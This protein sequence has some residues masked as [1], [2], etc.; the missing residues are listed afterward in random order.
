MRDISCEEAAERHGLTTHHQEMDNGEYRF[1]LRKSDGTVYIRTESG[2]GGWQQ[3]HYHENVRETYIVQ[4]G[5][6][7]FAERIQGERKISIYRAGQQFTTEPHIIHN[8]YMPANA[9]IH[10]VKHGDAAGEDRIHDT[11][12][13]KQF[14]EVTLPLTE[15]QIM[16]EA[17]ESS[18][19]YTAEYRHF[20]TL[21]WQLPAWC[22]AIFLVTAVGTNSIEQAKFLTQA[23]GL[24]RDVVATG[25]LSLMA[26][27]ILALSH[28]LYRFRKHQASFK[29]V[30]GTSFWS[31]ASTYLQ[32]IITLEAFALLFLVMLINGLKLYIALA[33]CLFL[34][35][36]ITI[37][38]EC[39][40]R[41]RRRV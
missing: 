3:S 34:L 14:D 19:T 18:E 1:R 2:S 33:V 32:I 41:R 6:I 37:F 36:L 21:I 39:V 25:F 16:S 22:T 35:A 10:T 5:W 30:P 9:V 29:Q 11:E 24:E 13:T 23:T 7:A 38:R 15:D 31:S 12:A 4:R 17:E 27:V 8:L 26:I 28:A 20:D 40:L